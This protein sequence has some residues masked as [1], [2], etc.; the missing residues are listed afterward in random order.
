MN[1]KLKPALIGGVALGIL[2]AIPF[3]STCCC[4]WALLGGLLATYLYVKNSPAPASVGDGAMLGAMAGVVGVVI[5]LVVGIPVAYAMGPTSRELLFKLME[6]MDP[7]Q[8][9]R[10]RAEME[11]SATSIV[12]FIIQ[13]LVLGVVLFV[14]SVIGGL[15]GVPIFEKRKGGPP[16]PP[17]MAGGPGAYAP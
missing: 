9:A 12:P 10:M 8:A 2:S 7:A 16:P 1:D 15:I 14:F 5:F 4:L 3:V 17:N 11:N 6:N 13:G